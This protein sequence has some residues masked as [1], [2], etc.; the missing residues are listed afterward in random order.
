MGRHLILARRIMG[1]TRLAI[2]TS[3]KMLEVVREQLSQSEANW[4]ASKVLLSK[5]RLLDG[6]HAIRSGRRS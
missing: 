4:K 5:S 1:E 3:R 2:R 6:E